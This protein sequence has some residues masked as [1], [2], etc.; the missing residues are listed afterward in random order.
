MIRKTLIIAVDLRS[1]LIA[2]K[3]GIVQ[4]VSMFL[5]IFIIHSHCQY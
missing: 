1:M 4:N 2:D 3:R 5:L